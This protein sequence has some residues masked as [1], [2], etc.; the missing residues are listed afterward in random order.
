M[1]KKSTFMICLLMLL[2]VPIL[3]QDDLPSVSDMPVGEWTQINPGGDT[4][5]ALGDEYKFFVRPGESDN[6]LIHFQGGG[7]CWD[8]GTCVASYTAR[9]AGLTEAGL[10]KDTVADG[11]GMGY[12]TGLFDM[13]NSPAGDYS[14]VLVPYCSGDIHIGDAEHTYTIPGTDQEYSVDHNGVNNANA[15]LDWTFANFDA[16]SQVMVTGCSAGAYGSIG[17]VPTIIDNYTDSSIVHLA[18]AGVGGLTPSDFVGFA[19]WNFYANAFDAVAE[20]PQ[21]E[22]TTTQQYIVT[23]QAYPDVQ[24][25]QSTSFIDNVQIFFA[26]LLNGV[27]LSDGNAVAAFGQE[28]ATDMMTG[29]ATINATVDNYDSFISGG[30]EHCIINNPLFFQFSADGVSFSDWVA[31][32]MAMGADDVSCNL[33]S[34]ECLQTPSAD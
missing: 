6:L 33:A 2:V 14:V 8:E 32:L 19:N 23:A 20:I 27:D 15:V 10:Y 34:G 28:W 18:D 13:E 11:E 31:D 1:I 5:C 21:D 12:M 4:I 3:A 17:H 26:A 7:A 16:L 29:Q 30:S 24:F 22:F 25:A 9:D